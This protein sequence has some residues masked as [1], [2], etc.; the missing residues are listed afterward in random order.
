MKRSIL[1]AGL[2]MLCSSWSQAQIRPPVY[3]VITEGTT[4][5]HYW[6]DVEGADGYR[7][8]FA[9][10]PNAA[11]VSFVDYGS[12]VTT[13]VTDQEEGAHFY[14]AVTAIKCLQCF[15]NPFIPGAIFGLEDESAWSNIE[16][17]HATSLDPADASATAAEIISNVAH[18]VIAANYAELE[19]R[20]AVLL[21]AVY[22]VSFDTSGE[23]LLTAQQAWRNARRAWEQTEAFLFGPVDTAGLD[24]AIDSWPVNRVDLDAV[25]NSENVLTE[26]FVGNL[27]DTLKGFHTIEYLL[28]GVGSAKP[29][30][31]LT[32]RQKEYLV[33]AALNLASATKTLADGWRPGEDSYLAEFVN[34]GTTSTIY[35]STTSALQELVEGMGII[36]D[37]VGNGK[38]ADPFDERNTELVESQF[39]YNSIMDFADNIRGIENV[40]IGR[41]L[42]NDGPGLNDLVKRTNATD[43]DQRMRTAITTAI[44]E[45]EKIPHPFRSAIS[46]D[47]GRAQIETAQEAVL[48]LQLLIE[49]ELLS[50]VL[51]H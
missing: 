27:G 9:P 34:A 40:Y 15:G 21:N 31:D 4:V 7:I 1:A 33:A 22:A 12:D 19:R 29:A 11:P 48:N 16:I 35:T 41:Y 25:L 24:P 10:F 23:N 28:F 39:S 51:S 43:L 36:A 30:S 8:Y 46:T 2:F 49:G 38:I 50:H 42:H 37:E 17:V 5:T 44:S 18:T 3:S 26:D 47:E 14:S 32:A 6:D 13:V 45:I 20:A